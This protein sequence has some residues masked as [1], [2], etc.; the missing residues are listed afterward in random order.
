[1][2]AQEDDLLSDRED[3]WIGA[4]DDSD[5]DPDYTELPDTVTEDSCDD[6]ADQLPNEDN[7]LGPSPLLLPGVISKPMPEQFLVHLLPGHMPRGQEQSGTGPLQI[8]PP[9]KA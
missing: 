4:S 5:N 9:E 3:E 6:V 2:Q 1:M 8:F 7:K